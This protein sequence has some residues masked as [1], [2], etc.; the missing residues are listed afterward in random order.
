MSRKTKSTTFYN[1]FKP[2]SPKQTKTGKLYGAMLLFAIGYM[3]IFIT[4]FSF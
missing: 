2:S 4:I 3:V 1:F